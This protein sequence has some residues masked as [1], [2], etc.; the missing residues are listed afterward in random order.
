VF[1]S[2]RNT[3]IKNN[4]RAALSKCSVGDMPASKDVDIED[5]IEVMATKSA[6]DEK[7]RLGCD[8][9]VG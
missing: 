2:N 3:R 5:L 9:V 1:Q 6:G 4:L 7:E 8:V